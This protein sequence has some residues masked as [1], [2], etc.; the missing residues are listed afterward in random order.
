M[1]A[2]TAAL[3]TAD[4]EASCQVP[5][6][7]TQAAVDAGVLLGYGGMVERLVA[8]MMRVAAGPAAVVVTGGNAERLLRHSRLRPIHVPDLVHRGLVL[9]ETR[10]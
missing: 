4:L 3:P 10:A 6:A 2:T 9:L 5:P 7:S 1:A 8:E